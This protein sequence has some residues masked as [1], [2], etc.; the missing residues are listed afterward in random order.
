MPVGGGG[1]ERGPVAGWGGVSEAQGG[2]LAQ[3]PAGEAG[4]G[5]RRRDDGV[6]PEGRGWRARSRGE[7]SEQERE[8]SP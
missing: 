7:G 3:G 6:G 4:S 5:G 8:R 1:S 2:W